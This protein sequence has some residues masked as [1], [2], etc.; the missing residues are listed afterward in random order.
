MGPISGQLHISGARTIRHFNGL[1]E[2]ARPRLAASP[3]ASA[4]LRIA[5]LLS[6]SCQQ[7]VAACVMPLPVKASAG[8]SEES[9]VPQPGTQSPLQSGPTSCSSCFSHY[10]SV[11]IFAQHSE[12]PGYARTFPLLHLCG[13][14]SSA[15]R[16]SLPIS[17]WQVPIC[18]SRK[19]LSH[20]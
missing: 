14:S 17:T 9:H 11:P 4:V 10:S 1:A 8:P 20:V 18:L 2:P 15:E 19:L 6:A 7:R 5:S 3:R 16:A 13:C 12:R